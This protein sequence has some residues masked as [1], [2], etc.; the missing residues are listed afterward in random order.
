MPLARRFGLLNTT[1]FTHLPSNVLLALV[2]FA[3]TFPVAAALLLLRQALSQMDVPTRRAYTMALVEPSERSAAA[4]LTSLA[5]SVGS[6]TSPVFS[7]MLLQGPL[8]VLG[9]PFILAGALKAAYDLTLWSIFRRVPVPEE[10]DRSRQTPEHA[11]QST[12]TPSQEAGASSAEHGR[13]GNP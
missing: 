8:L 12:F 11:P 4:S 9:L 1:V 6:S 13:R 5:R 10:E 3:P 2:A 7:G